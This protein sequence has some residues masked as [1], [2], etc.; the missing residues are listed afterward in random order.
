MKKNSKVYF[1]GET[2]LF[3]RRKKN[4]LILR[5]VS[6]DVADVEVHQRAV[7]ALKPWAERKKRKID[8]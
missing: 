1:C 4:K 5:S 8:E 7:R 2:W 3:V 6:K